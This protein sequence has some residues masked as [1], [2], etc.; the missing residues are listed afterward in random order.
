MV[1]RGSVFNRRVR[2]LF[3]LLILGAILVSWNHLAAARGRQSPPEYAAVG[4]V[5]AVAAVV[6]VS[7][8]TVVNSAKGMV[9]AR[10]L[11]E[12]N[13]RLRAENAELEARITKLFGYSLENKRYKELLKL[14]ESERAGVAAR[15]IA[16][17][18]GTQAKR[19][20]V[21]KGRLDGI[22]ERFI[23]VAPA[24]L[25]GRVLADKLGAHTAEIALIIDPRSGVAGMVLASGDKGVVVGDPSGPG[26]GGHLLSMDLAGDAVVRE[27]DVIISSGYGGVYPRGYRIGR[28]VSVKRNPAD[29][30]Q[31][32][33]IRPF[34]DFAHLEALLLV[35]AE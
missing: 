5:N 12:E 9:N 25:V 10:A 21:N 19:V 3:P 33:T 2:T 16:A 28:V 34:V 22:G 31:V 13:K 15:V 32:A 27:G 24:G 14:Q 29:A 17:E 4:I 26:L 18:A 1:K 35:P 7:Y 6:S 20:T 11:V 8:N 30:S 23:A